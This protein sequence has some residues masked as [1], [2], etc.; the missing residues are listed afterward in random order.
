ML[1]T[2]K[3][4]NNV[5]M[6]QDADGNELV[7][8]GKGIGFRST[9]YE[10]EDTSSIQRVFHDVNEDLLQTINSIS[11]EVIGASLDIVKLAESKL[12]CTLNPNLYLTLADHLQFA[13]ERVANGIVIE[14]P[15]AD[16]VPYVYP[17][18]YEVG[19]EG[20]RIM[21]EVTGITLPD[22]EPCSIALH[23]ANAE[24]SGA[25]HASSMNDVMKAVEIINEVTELLEKRYHCTIDRSSHSYTRFVAHLRY[26]IKR[27]QRGGEAESP[28][29]IAILESVAKDFPQANRSAEAIARLFKRKYHW[30]LSNEE[31]LYLMMYIVRLDPK[32]EG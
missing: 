10:L 29:D 23:L 17:A 28:H 3:I 22:T 32:R 12:Q 26:L 9:P 14:N 24:G 19:Q 20:V 7:V 1:I 13:A 18:E 21:R 31:K 8:F 30:V 2:K 4:N 15:L 25:D 16:E 11:A 5:A 6:A 27:L